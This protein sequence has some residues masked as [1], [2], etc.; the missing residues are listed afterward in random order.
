MK[1]GRD[2]VEKSRKKTEENEREDRRVWKGM[3]KL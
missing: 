2:I 1:N 3:G